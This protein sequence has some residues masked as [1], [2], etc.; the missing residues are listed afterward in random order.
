MSITLSVCELLQAVLRDTLSGSGREELE[1]PEDSEVWVWSESLK[2]LESIQLMLSDGD[3]QVQSIECC[4]RAGTSC[5]YFLSSSF[6]GVDNGH[7]LV[8]R[9]A[10]RCLE[11]ST[12]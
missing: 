9:T 2:H 6:A 11:T 7:C 10:Q 4:I 8:V 12:H 3:L 1:F 5:T